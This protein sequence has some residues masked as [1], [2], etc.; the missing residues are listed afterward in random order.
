MSS[1]RPQ[2]PNNHPHPDLT[3]PSFTGTSFWYFLRGIMRVIDPAT[4][5][6]WF[7][8][9]IDMPMEPNGKPRTSP[10]SSSHPNTFHTDLE[11]YTTRTDAF[12]LLSL[13]AILLVISDAI[14]LPKGLT[15]SQLADTGNKKPYARAI[16]LI[17]ILHHIATGIGSYSH[18]VR[19]SHHTIAMDIGVYGNIF[20]TALG[21]VALV[22]GLG[23]EENGGNELRSGKKL[24]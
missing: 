22:Y 17:T 19:P 4:V 10:P 23:K 6:G 7:R 14:P 9:P 11:L 5:C 1:V 3:I 15:G 24:S 2:N 13:S 18:W 20:F 8:P 16:V 12:C 21:V